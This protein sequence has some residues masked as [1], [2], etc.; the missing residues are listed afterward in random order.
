MGED[1]LDDIRLDRIIAE[2]RLLI[3][4]IEEIEEIYFYSEEMA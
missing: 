1:T 4:R 2:R 3:E